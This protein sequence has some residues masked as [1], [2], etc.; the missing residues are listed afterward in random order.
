MATHTTVDNGALIVRNRGATLNLQWGEA[1]RVMPPGVVAA[2]HDG[3]RLS[4]TWAL[5]NQGER[6]EFVFGTV[7]AAR[8]CVD[9]IGKQIAQA[10]RQGNPAGGAIT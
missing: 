7:A 5:G 2:G 1:A 8:D 9:D 4:I 10:L 3:V 6:M